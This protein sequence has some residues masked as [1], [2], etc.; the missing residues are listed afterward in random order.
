MFAEMFLLHLEIEAAARALNEAQE[1][2]KPR[3]VPFYPGVSTL[4]RA[5]TKHA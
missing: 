1:A 2:A 5:R 4:R 3:F